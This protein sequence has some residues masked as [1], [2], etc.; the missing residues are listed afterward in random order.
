M[1]RLFFVFIT[2]CCALMFTS[3]NGVAATKLIV[4]SAAAA[5]DTIPTA[6]VVWKA[7]KEA[8]KTTAPNTI[9]VPNFESTLFYVP[10][11]SSSTDVVFTLTNALW[12]APA[13]GQSWYLCSS[14]GNY[15]LSPGSIGSDKLTFDLPTAGLVKTR[16]YYLFAT[17]S[18]LTKSNVIK[19]PTVSA[20]NINMNVL[21]NATAT[22]ID[23]SVS[24][25]G[26]NEASIG[27]FIKWSNFYSL[28]TTAAD[29]VVDVAADR[30]LF[31]GKAKADDVKLGLHFSDTS[32][33]AEINSEGPEAAAT[34]AIASW[35]YR[36]GTGDI[37]A[38]STTK[39]KVGTDAAVTQTYDTT[40]QWYSSTTAADPSGATPYPVTWTMTVTGTDV[41][42]T[43][44]FTGT[45]LGT[46]AASYSDVYYANAASAGAWTINGYQGQLPYLL[47]GYTGYINFLKVTNSGSTTATIY[48]DVWGYDYTAAAD[49]VKVSNVSL[50][51]VGAD[52]LITISD[53]TIAT[54]AGLDATH[55]YHLTV[56]L[57]GTV[58]PEFINVAGFQKDSVGRTMLPVY[59]IGD[60]AIRQ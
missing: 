23:L 41:I 25:G 31:T 33:V 10:D 7:T 45:V 26:L 32:F 11:Y 59:V 3:G 44:T 36:L 12:G 42:D 47:Y 16:T 51:T 48:A 9:G 13:S 4:N 15:T 17:V 27:G 46:A 28:K 34:G 24:Q 58:S 49:L 56:Q 57:T 22:D 2:V 54:A 53:E 43:R 14:S 40:N 50:G 5:G 29:A 38:I 6:N 8:Y 60:T 20:G 21:T 55:K 18:G 19:A 39:L 30:K 35:T 1:R 37:G 52:S